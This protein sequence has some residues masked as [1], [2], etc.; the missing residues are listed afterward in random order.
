MNLGVIYM[1]T[2]P[3]SERKF[4]NLEEL[5]LSDTNTEGLLYKF[6]YHGED[7]LLKKLHDCDG[8]TLAK[9][10]FIV[11]VLNSNDLPEYFITPDRLVSVKNNVVGFTIPY[12]DGTTLRTLLYNDN[13]PIELKINYLKKIGI[14]LD[15]M[16]GIR[17]HTDLRHFYLNDIHESNF[18]IDYNTGELCVI[19]L[20][21]CKI[22]PS[23]SFPARYLT[24]S[25]LFNNTHK[26]NIEPD[27]RHGTYVMANRD[28]DLY[29]YIIIILNY[30]YGDC[31]NNM[32][33]T[34][35]YDYLNYLDDIGINKDLLN[36]FYKI[37]T[38][39]DN[40]N[41]MEYLDSLTSQQ[42]CRAK[43]NVY[44]IVKNK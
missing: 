5:K 29:C 33:I 35:Y 11:E 19:D 31:V 36:S 15:D 10:L 32:S 17:S 37:V 6:S 28:S 1:K 43:S 44:R 34:N 9:K 39:G 7:K 23:F 14:I 24:S 13:Y 30:L 42:V 8:I 2:L 25:G 27:L 26:Y 21:G 16:V 40:I 20:D 38:Y 12:I 22:S 18:M 41:P 4:N 3:I